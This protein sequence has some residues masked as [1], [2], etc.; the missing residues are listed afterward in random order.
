MRN[1]LWQGNVNLNLRGANGKGS[2]K[3]DVQLTDGGITG[4][5]AAQSLPLEVVGIPLTVS[6]DVKLDKDTFAAS[7]AAQTLG[8]QVTASG[9]GGLADLVPF[10]TQYTKAEPG[11]YGYTLRARLDT[12]KLEDIAFV[13]QFAP[14]A[15][16]RAV[17]VVQVTDGISNFQISVPELS[18]PNLTSNPG[19]RVRLGLRVTGTSAGSSL[20]Y[21]GRLVGL[22]SEGSL[23]TLAPDLNAFGES[24]FSGSFDGNTA[25]GLL[26]MRRAPLHSL[27]GSV[28]GALPG[29]AIASGLARYTLPVGQIAKSEFRVA[30]EKLEIEGGGDRLVGFGALSFKNGNFVLDTLDLRGKGRWTG[31]GR[32]TRDLVDL[33]L[34]FEDTSFTP[35]LAVIPNLR[36]YN[37]DASGTVRLK[38]SGRYENPNAALEVLNFKGNLSGI[39]L[40]APRLEGS[41]QAG[42]LKISGLLSSDES[43]GATLQTTATAKV[44]SFS[45]VNVTDLEARATGSLNIKPVGLIENVD[46]RVFGASGGFKLELNGSKGGPLSIKGDLSPV[47][48]L[49]LTGRDLILPI[50]DYFV[51]D[52]LL[53]AD[54]NFRGDGGRAYILGGE[55]NIARL[56]VALNQGQRAATTPATPGTPSSTAS[57]PSAPRPSGPNPFLEQ[58]KLAGIRINAPQ[59]LRLNESFATLEAGGALTL[60]GTAAAPEATG[61]LEALGSSSGRGSI[62]LGANSYTIQNATATFSAVDGLF[63]VVAVDSKGRVRAPLRKGAET[64]TQE[65][66]VNLRLNIRWVAD[67]ASG[68]E[69]KLVIE[70]FLSA[71]VPAGF[72]DLSQ[73]ELYSLVTLGSTSG[74]TLGGLGQQALDTAFGLFFLSEFSRQFKD[75][76]GVDLNVT[77]NLFDFIFTQG[78]P[79]EQQAQL[80]FTFSVGFD[81]SR[82]VRLDLQ[83]NT[84]GTGSVNLNYQSDDGRFGIRFST[85][86]D[87]NAGSDTGGFFGG[88]QPEF[89][90]SY[91]LSSL[92]AFTL[93]FQ[94]VGN[95]NFSFKFGFG[96]RF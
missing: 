62:R 86:F 42:D 15:T 44:R 3:G 89:S 4:A 61:L 45:P 69:R 59:G 46:A 95:N 36:E 81:L 94:Y 65:I 34:D 26:E 57:N 19:E 75:A 53:D 29:S 96:F 72:E 9:S 38:L 5:A 68:G 28:I 83:L 50:P 33:N 54:L 64:V 60:N 55:V 48:N 40:S 37:P 73:S 80:R 25:S 23:E 92:N 70:P 16:G 22:P 20:R 52:S 24:L 30:L 87:L 84:Q 77:A 93:G 10:L 74:L 91:N 7:G 78:L 71:V 32:Y 79:P 35:V 82:A 43:L 85:P 66:D 41:L 1:K 76:T 6:G 51:S 21:S 12:V 58:I 14:Y 17:G 18:L 56:L 13:K 31:S 47:L 49:R 90:L 88:I 63:P 11:E 2:I 67:A 39:A 8:G 27:L